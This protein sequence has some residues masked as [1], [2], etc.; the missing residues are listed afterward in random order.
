MNE[1]N[2]ISCLTLIK[3]VPVKTDYFNDPKF[4]DI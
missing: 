1:I 2:Q 3:L 4:S